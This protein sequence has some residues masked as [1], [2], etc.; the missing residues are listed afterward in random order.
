LASGVGDSPAANR[1]VRGL[2]AVAFVGAC[3]DSSWC[4]WEHE[5]WLRDLRVRHE[6]SGAQRHW[7]VFTGL[8][9]RFAEA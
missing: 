9:L 5:T 4:S 2:V 1:S 8:T 7:K 6:V 3:G